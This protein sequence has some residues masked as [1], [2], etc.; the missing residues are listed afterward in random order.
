MRRDVVFH[1][2]ERD[3]V[4]LRVQHALFKVY[5]LAARIVRQRVGAPVV[6][7]DFTEPCLRGAESPIV[8]AQSYRRGGHSIV[9]EDLPF[10]SPV[11]SRM[12]AWIA[13]FDLDR[14]LCF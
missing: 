4:V 2:R 8:E 3:L 9:T 13:G 11:F 6:C 1:R 14:D 12:L 5:L 10:D 7:L